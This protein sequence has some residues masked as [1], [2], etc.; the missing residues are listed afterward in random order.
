MLH[1]SFA[2]SSDDIRISINFGFHLYRSVLGQKTALVIAEQN[3]IYDAQRFHDRSTVIAVAID[4]R[5][6]Y[7]LN[8]TPFSYKPFADK[9]DDYRFNW[10]AVRELR[11]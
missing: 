5:G 1:G 11:P 8:E 4:A 9:A 6:Q 3:T 2:N 10:E 7:Y